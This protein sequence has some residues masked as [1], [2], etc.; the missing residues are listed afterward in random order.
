M[1]TPHTTCLCLLVVS[2]VTVGV[3]AA[4]TKDKVLYVLEGGHVLNT[5]A[6]VLKHFKM[7]SP[8]ATGQPAPTGEYLRAGAMAHVEV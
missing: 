7:M 2:S 1:L 8:K 4:G 3:H 6:K 5:R